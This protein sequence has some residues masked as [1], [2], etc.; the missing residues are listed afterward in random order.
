[1]KKAENDEVFNFRQ[2]A[3]GLTYKAFKKYKTLKSER[4]EKLLGCSFEFF[5]NHLL[6]TF[7]NTYGYEWDGIEPVHIDHII[8]YATAKSVEDVIKL[9]HYTNTQLLK[10]ID[11][12]KKGKKINYKVKE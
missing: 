7:K 10:P 12:E 11:N 1:M 5:H 9:S 3:G 6:Q 8:P 2:K 4:T